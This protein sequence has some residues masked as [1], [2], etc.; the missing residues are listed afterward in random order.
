MSR[1]AA[2][3]IILLTTGWTILALPTISTAQ[4]S[5]WMGE[6]VVQAVNGTPWRTGPFRGSAAFRLD[7]AGYDSDIYYGF[8]LD[9]V[10]DYRLSAVLDTRLFITLKDRLVLDIS[11]RPEYQYYQ[12]TKNERVWN[13]WL[14]GEA[15]LIL[16]RTYVRA[17]VGMANI[18]ERL[19]PELSLNVRRKEDSVIG[20]AFWQTSNEVSLAFQFRGYSFRYQDPPGGEISVA[21]NLNRQ[22]GYFNFRAYWQRSPRIR[23]Y[24]DAEFGRFVFTESASSLRDSRSYSGYAGVEFLPQAGFEGRTRGIY[25]RINIGYRTF[26]MDESWRGNF[27]GLV[28][29]SGISIAV[30]RRSAIRFYLGRTLQYSA[31]SDYTYYLQTFAGIGLSRY[32][33]RRTVLTYDFFYGI[34][35]YP[36]FTG[37]GTSSDQ[38]DLQSHLVRLEYRLARNIQLSLMGL[39]ANRGEGIYIIGGKRF[40]IGFSV[41]FGVPSGETP[42]LA[43]PNAQ[44]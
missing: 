28:G 9:D 6:S 24:L 43:N 36:W 4:I 30:L 23:L 3:M 20:L 37:G 13:N 7:N 16:K 5:N 33:T 8:A 10:P 42:F 32:L 11:E 14:R 27:E 17:G 1:K 40:F 29:N 31:F 21:E 15:H 35:K 12:R 44:F 22:E 39:L 34:I 38:T 26:V 19:S 25:G 41:I 18:R 2:G